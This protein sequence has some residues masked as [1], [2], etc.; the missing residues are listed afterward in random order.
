MIVGCYAL[1]LY[2]D[3][4][5]LRRLVTNGP[6]VE[7]ECGARFESQTAPETAALAHREARSAGWF[8]ALRSRRLPNGRALCPL[9]VAARGVRSDY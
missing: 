8:L 6:I 9:C 2:C 7:R 3:G 5:V 4:R 1:H